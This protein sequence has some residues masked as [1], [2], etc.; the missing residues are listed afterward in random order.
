M[1]VNIFAVW[2]MASNITALHDKVDYCRVWF[3]EKSYID[4]REKTCDAVA[5]EINEKIIINRKR[6]L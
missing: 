1:L 4:F 6:Y 5:N 2:L 3:V